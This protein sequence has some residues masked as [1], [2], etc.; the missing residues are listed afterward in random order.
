[1]SLK[2]IMS[3]P[4]REFYP[5]RILDV[6]ITLGD[7]VAADTPAM[8]AETAKGQRIT[9]TC[10]YAGRIINFL[11]AGTVLEKRQMLLLIEFFDDPKKTTEQEVNACDKQEKIYPEKEV[12]TSKENIKSSTTVKKSHFGKRVFAGVA[13]ISIACVS[14]YIL[15]YTDTFK[16]PEP[17]D[18]TKIAEATCTGKFDGLGAMKIGAYD[19]K[20]TNAMTW[21][22]WLYVNKDCVTYIGYGSEANKPLLAA[23]HVGDAESAY[24]IG[25]Y[26]L[27]GIRGFTRDPQGG[28]K[29]LQKA[30]DEGSNEAS[31]MLADEYISGNNLPQNLS[32][33]KKLINRMER[34]YGPNSDWMTG[35]LEMNLRDAQSKLAAKTRVITN[36][37][38]NQA[39]LNDSAS[40]ADSGV[41]PEDPRIYPKGC[42][43]MMFHNCKRPYSKKV[44]SAIVIKLISSGFSK[45]LCK[46]PLKGTT[47]F[48]DTDKYQDS[49]LPEQYSEQMRNML[50]KFVSDIK[51][52]H[53]DC[54]QDKKRPL[55]FNLIIRYLGEKEGILSRECWIKPVS[56]NYNTPVCAR[57]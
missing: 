53:P 42:Y 34:R 9:I 28:E 36:N 46:P 15:T 39:L 40:I 52:Y 11:P 23:A 51:K 49:M 45:V 54:K 20:S 56:H 21:L 1:M 30:V 7:L 37:I 26:M 10:T 32:H 6:Y 17:G 43:L 5:I 50:S 19:D 14:L 44:R 48:P 13:I 3:S 16:V 31:F 2:T 38:D 18:Y 27:Q 33:A 12:R 25:S 29:W 47:Y 8:I 35:S 22:R 55:P 4:H 57:F 41:P 24:T